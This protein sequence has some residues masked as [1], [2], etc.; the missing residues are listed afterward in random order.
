MFLSPFV[1][2]KHT[3][4]V[5][6]DQT[7]YYHHVY[8]HVRVTNINYKGS[9]TH[10]NQSL[11]HITY[12][13]THTCICTISPLHGN[14]CWCPYMNSLSTKHGLIHL[15][16][17]PMFRSDISFWKSIQSTS[18]AHVVLVILQWNLSKAVTIGLKIDDHVDRWQNHLYSSHI[19]MTLV[20]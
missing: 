13:T 4:N 5:L 12:H 2:F 17:P 19:L 6:R 15:H 14:V 11:E 18:H 20:M 1:T 10:T 8:L 3:I 16:A 7:L 9:G